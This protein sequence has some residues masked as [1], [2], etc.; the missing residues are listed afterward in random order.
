MTPVNL[1]GGIPD[2]DLRGNDVKTTTSLLE[3][4][5][6]YVYTHH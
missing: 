3:K 1:F 2:E 5:P 4:P 6:S